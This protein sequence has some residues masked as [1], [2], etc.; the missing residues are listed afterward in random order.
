MSG[1]QWRKLGEALAP[2]H[3]VLTPDFLGSGEH[4]HGGAVNAELTRH[5]LAAT[6]PRS[7]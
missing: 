5:I 4:P 2:T 7:P 3:R 6:A 1:R